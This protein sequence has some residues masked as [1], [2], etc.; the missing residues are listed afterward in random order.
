MGRTKLSFN[1]ED[2][3]SGEIRQ[4]EPMSGHTSLRIGGPADLMLFPEDPVSLKNLFIAARREDIP[5]CFLGGGTNMLVTDRGIRGMVISLRAF[6]N[7]DITRDSDSEKAVLYIGA[8]VLMAQL[9]GF[10]KKNGLSGIEGLAG[11]PGTVGGA[12]VMNAGSF[13]TEIKDVIE[14]V[15][16]MDMDGDIKRYK[17]DE[18]DFGY[19]SSGLQKDVIVLDLRVVLQKDEPDRVGGRMRE[20]IARKRAS[21]PIGEASCGCV[22]KNPHGDAAG[23]LIEA[24]GCKGMKS[25]N[26]EVSNLH[27]NYFIN[28]GG[29]QCS[30]FVEL[31]NAVS[32]K[33]KENSGIE[34]E[35]EVRI[36]GEAA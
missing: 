27:A 12:A 15:G 30:E 6:G 5:V 35:P 17:A 26:I 25:G 29:G 16:V 28:R 14:S 7:I 33:V 31:M 11:I 3:F 4:D 9:H 10:A 1:I 23:R 19:R 36:L 32:L 13:G 8:G 21:Q 20:F 22:F 2:L 18:L 34:L 24:A